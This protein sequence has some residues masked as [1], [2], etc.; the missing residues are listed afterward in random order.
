MPADS[1]YFLADSRVDKFLWV[2]INA[3]HSCL[4]LDCR[5]YE[6]AGGL[7]I[8]KTGTAFLGVLGSCLGVRF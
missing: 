3:Q 6:N 4:C 5:L 8:R 1:R 2:G 7:S